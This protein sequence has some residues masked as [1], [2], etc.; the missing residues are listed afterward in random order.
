[1]TEHD[2]APGATPSRFSARKVLDQDRQHPA[3]RSRW[4]HPGLHYTRMRC[5]DGGP[6]RLA[7]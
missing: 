5:P 1:M 3:D 4:P 6:A 2:Q 7:R